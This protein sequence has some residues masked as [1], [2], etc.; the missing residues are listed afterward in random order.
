M[1]LIIVNNEQTARQ[2]LEVHVL[3]NK[4]VEGWIRPLD[5]DINSVFDRERNKAFRHGEC[6]RWILK[7]GN[8]QLIG[9]MA[10]FVSK[11]YKNKGDE[12]PVGGIGFFDC[13]DNQEAANLLFDTGKQWLQERGMEAM[14]GPINF[15]ERNNWWGLL[16]E[17][18]YEPLYAMNFNPPYYVR[19]FEQYGFQVFFHQ[20]C[21]GMKVADTLQ[22]KFYDRHAAIAA[23]PAFKAVHL[24]KNDL[25]KFAE[26]FCTVYNK[27][28]AK[29]G[30]GKDMGKAQAIALFKQMKPLLDEKIAWFVYHQE[31]PIAIWLN[32]PDLNQYI[33]LM[34][35]KFGLLQKLKFLYLKQ[36]GYCKKMTGIIFGVVP[37]F[38]GKG[39]D[40][41]TIVEGA[42]L[43]QSGA[44]KYVD[45][46]M[47]WIGDFNPKMQNVAESLGASPSRQ[48]TTYRYLFD[49]SK[50]FHRHPIIG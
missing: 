24:R 20:I 25:R 26:D 35:G 22:P 42:K 43:I 48:L 15:G 21:Y 4:D 31:E 28:W 1:Q 50:P 33:K 23:D 29:H 47:Q 3:L 12:C 5:K 14:D 40:A 18:Y 13:I 7:D 16:T 19:L 2:F 49:R 37:E 11:K 27:A 38:Q 6:V 32:L 41:F 17:G 10:A 39:V 44:V 9:R 46:E 8:G 36:M 30:G 34:N 45:Y